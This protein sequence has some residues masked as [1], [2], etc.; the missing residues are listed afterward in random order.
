[1][2]MRDPGCRFELIASRSGYTYSTRQHFYDES[3]S[4]RIRF[5]QPGAAPRGDL[6]HAR[7]GQGRGCGSHAHIGRRRHGQDQ[8][9][10][11][12]YR[13]SG[14]ERRGSG[15][16]FDADLHA[17]RCSGNDS[18]HPEHRRGGPGGPGQGGRSQR[19]V[20]DAVVGD[21]SRRGQPDIAPVRQA[22]GSGSRTSRCW[23]VRMR[24][25]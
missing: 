8:H 24:P 14:A 20:A 7:G 15:P 12:P 9:P 4:Q 17:P 13:A 23:T 18:A 2:E 16:D 5:A 3:Q 22:S 21:F 1:M 11:A 19:G 25:I 10:G 6:R